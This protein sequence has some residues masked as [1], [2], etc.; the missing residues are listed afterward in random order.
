[1][2][3]FQ[4]LSAGLSLL[5]MLTACS[6]QEKFDDCVDRGLQF[7]K[8]HGSYPIV[9]YAPDVATKTTNKNSAHLGTLISASS[10]KFP[11]F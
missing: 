10:L 6:N 9:H 5:L 11:D 2:K 3:E 4:G 1:V 8:E 7:Y